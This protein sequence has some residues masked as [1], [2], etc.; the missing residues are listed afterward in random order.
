MTAHSLRFP[1]VPGWVYCFRMFNVDKTP[2]VKVGATT[3]EPNDRLMEITYQGDLFDRPELW[4]AIYVNNV[5]QIEHIAHQM[6]SYCHVEKEL[7]K[8]DPNTAVEAI[9]SA[10]DIY[11]LLIK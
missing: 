10:N 3:R 11:S 5:W 7:F 1:A 8:V 4:G 9:E 2:V 6:L